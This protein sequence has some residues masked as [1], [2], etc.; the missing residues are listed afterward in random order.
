MICF[1][2]KLS[3]FGNA[4]GCIQA[5][6][7][8]IINKSAFSQAEIYSHKKSSTFAFT[9]SIFFNQFNLAFSFQSSDAE[10]TISTL[11]TCFAQAFAKIIPIVQVQPY[12]SSTI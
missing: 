11:F 1:V 4:P 3:I 6:G 10:V 2:P 5:L 9:K 8:S 7:G 12:K